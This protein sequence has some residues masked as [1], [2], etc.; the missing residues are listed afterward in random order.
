MGAALGLSELVLDRVVASMAHFIQALVVLLWLVVSG[1]IGGTLVNAVKPFE[2]L[3]DP[4][5][6]VPVIWQALFVP[7]LAINLLIVFQNSHFDAVWAVLCEGVFWVHSGF[8][9]KHGNLSFGRVV[10]MIF[11]ILWGNHYNQPHW[12]I[13]ISTTVLSVSDTIGF[14]G[15]LN[16]ACA[17][18][19]NGWCGTIPSTFV[20][21]RSD[22]GKYCTK[23]S[24]HSIMVAGNEKR[25]TS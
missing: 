9:C 23:D 14:R 17:R 22:C 12:L 13:L 15:I 6:P 7:L 1:F 19:Q 24:W 8:N 4:S 3:Y 2:T 5:E 16:V 20:N 11:A 21:C 25:A 10:Y 18:G